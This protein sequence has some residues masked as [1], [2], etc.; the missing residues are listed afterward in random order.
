MSSA[1]LQDMRSI[2]KYQLTFCTLVMNKSKNKIKKIIP[3]T[4]AS[5]VIKHLGVNLTIKYRIYKLKVQ[6]VYTK[7][8]K[9]CWKKLKMA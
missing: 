5:K 4:K 1:S 2:Y 8:I 7:N 6:D 9:H 3:F